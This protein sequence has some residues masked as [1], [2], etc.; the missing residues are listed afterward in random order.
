MTVNRK[1]LTYG[2]A[3]F[4]SLAFVVLLLV[5]YFI[6]KTSILNRAE[7]SLLFTMSEYVDDDVYYYNNEDYFDVYY[8]DLEDRE[9][10]SYNE[11]YLLDYYDNNDH[12][13]GV[14]Y[15][16]EDG[17]SII[18]YTVEEYDTRY[19][20]YTNVYPMI[21]ILK[22]VTLVL[23]F[24]LVL[25]DLFIIY[26][27][28]QVA[29]IIDQSDRRS[30]QFFANASHELKTPLMSIQG[31]AEGLEKNI[32]NKDQATAVILNESEKMSSL[33]ESI[34]NLSKVDS[35][36]IKPN[37]E[38]NDLRELLYE[39]IDSHSQI[40]KEE[41]IEIKF[42]LKEPI[43]VKYDEELML[44]VLNNIFS[45]AL[46][47]AK[48]WIKLEVD[49]SDHVSIKITNDGDAISKEALPKI[50][51]R[52]Y[53]GEKGQTG[54]GLALSKSYVELHQ[55]EILVTTGKTTTFDVRVPM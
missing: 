47:Y 52:F 53:K 51:D 49:I 21:K 12:E 27:G 46:R 24:I 39:V 15:Q 17:A 18:L 40:A 31:Y 54:I 50:F 35:Q 38:K 8:I 28:H 26:L 9:A 4:T 48:N 32:V 19:I 14:I 1:Y 45:N 25:L 34:L 41:G 42:D 29:K 5:F 37:F 2:L 33:V 20:Y 36:M 55:G 11:S 43:T 3:I 30:K 44:V 13:L 7:D 6:M 10:L 22:S 16:Y 23:F